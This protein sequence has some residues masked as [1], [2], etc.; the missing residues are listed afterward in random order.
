MIGP[1]LVINPNSNPNVTQ[2]LDAAMMSF[3]IN[4]S[5]LSNV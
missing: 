4:G 3:R 1:I 2:G 5:P